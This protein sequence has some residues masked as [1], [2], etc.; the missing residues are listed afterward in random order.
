MTINDDDC[1]IGMR[2][3]IA[4]L[5]GQLA[6]L[7]EAVLRRI[8]DA[9]LLATHPLNETIKTQREQIAQAVKD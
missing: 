3:E 8:D 6:E 9:V 7:E 4:Q 2:T 5:R 1:T